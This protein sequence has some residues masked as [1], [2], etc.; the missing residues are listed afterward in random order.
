VSALTTR[1]ACGPARVRNC[2]RVGMAEQPSASHEP[3]QVESGSYADRQ[4]N[5]LA[6]DGRLD[7]SRDLRNELG[8]DS[9]VS[10]SAVILTAFHRWRERCFA[11]LTGDW[12]LALWS[13]A[14]EVLYLARDHAGSRTLYLHLGAEEVTWSTYLETL[15]ARDPSVCVSR[16]YVASYM[17]GL[18]LRDLTPYDSIRSVP[19]GHHV[20]I[21]NGR[22]TTTTHWSPSS[23]KE[24][25][26][27]NDAEYESAF[28]ALFAQA[29]RRRADRSGTVLAELSGGMDSTS[30]VCMSDHLRRHEHTGEPLL[31]TVSYFDDDEVSLDER[32][33]FSIT[34]ATRGKVGTHLQMSF[35]ERTFRRHDPTKG[36]YLLPG[37]D[38]LSIVRE[39][40]FH[41]AVWYRGYRS[42]LSGIGGDELLGGVPDPKPELAIYLGRAECGRLIQQSV[43]WSLTD[44]SPMIGTLLSS[45]SYLGQ[46]YGLR[47]GSATLP[48]WL[49]PDSRDITRTI[50]RAR[51]FPH[52]WEYTAQQ[53]INERTWWAIMETLPHLF[54]RLMARPEYRYP[55]LD[56]D[57]VSFL[58]A[59]PRSQ[60]LRPNRRRSL[61]RRALVGIVPHDILERKAKAFQIRGAMHALRD[62]AS[63]LHTL[64]RE[65][66]LVEAKCVEGDAFRSALRQTCEGNA[67][68]MRTVLRTIAMELWLQSEETAPGHRIKPLNSS[69]AAN[70]RPS[71]SVDTTWRAGRVD[72]NF[73]TEENNHALYETHH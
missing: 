35:S 29:V 37:A 49:S 47:R 26:L 51:T 52:P 23:V 2:G 50:E 17:S 25:T 46:L 11:R 56:K 44:R 38:S 12:A 58:L 30:I 55:F 20:A 14:D 4:G 15:L 32:R 53:L 48:S 64:F 9:Y 72:G 62:A 73:T 16:T 61:M 5:L 45:L 28:L 19:P 8:L 27:S 70:G 33:Y 69:L 39:G 41:D 67:S 1:Y 42:L 63:A 10:D 34:E 18:Q 40:Q 22:C 13:A 59:I 66:R 54:P 31:D 43:A 36:R 71:G 68:Q 57:L 65:S 3:S 6:F 24:I 60:L 21:A 7:N